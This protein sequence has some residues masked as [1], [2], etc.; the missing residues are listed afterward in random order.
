MHFLLKFLHPLLPMIKYLYFILFSIQFMAC[1]SSRMTLSVTEP[2]P[3]FVPDDVRA[4]GIINRT[5]AK[6]KHKTLQKIDEVLSMEAK[7]QDI[8]GSIACIE[9]LYNSLVQRTRFETIVRIDSLYLENNALSALPPL[10][11][12][13][14]IE[15]LC[16]LYS[17]D[18]LIVLEH[19]DTDS[20]IDY[21]LN[22]TQVRT[23]IGLNVPAIEHQATVATKI[24]VTWRVY[25]PF[26]KQIYDEFPGNKQIISVGRGINP[27]KAVE[28]IT[29]RKAL[30][31]QNSMFLGQIYAQRFFP[32]RRRVARNY[33]S[34]PA[35][36]L[37]QAKRKAQTGNWE[38]AGRLWLTASKSSNPG[39]AGKGCYNV[40]ISHEINNQLE[41][42]LTWAQKSYEDY[43]NRQALEYCR[44]IRNRLR[45]TTFIRNN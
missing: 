1:S 6:T 31:E 11:E 4:V 3:V 42:A 22:Q 25:D 43:N 34:G 17:V 13:T 45:R 19:Y 44:I 26:T 16:S 35:A 20:K 2:A 28:S 7:N 10:L 23:P 39:L 32:Y 12:W 27:A 36:I 14:T 5:K 15:K 9:G 40:A 37:K 29:N 30:V 18:L 8:D 21:K 41:K 24:K 38:G 33:F